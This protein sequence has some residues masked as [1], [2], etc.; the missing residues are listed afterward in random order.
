MVVN[1]HGDAGERY[2]LRKASIHRDSA[3]CVRAIMCSLPPLH[4]KRPATPLRL[5]SIRQV[6]QMPLEQSRCRVR[7]INLGK[8]SL[9]S[10]PPTAQGTYL[11]KANYDY[12][13][14]VDASYRITPN[15]AHH[16]VSYTV[17][18]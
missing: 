10:L 9:A 14:P 12:D 15:E 5:K 4:S 13:T 1:A 18:L 16:A 8:P 3:L 6:A 11:E 7:R 17:L 2:L